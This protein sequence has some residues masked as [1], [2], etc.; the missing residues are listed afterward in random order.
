[1]GGQDDQHDAERERRGRDA[2][3]RDADARDTQPR[4]PLVVRVGGREPGEAPGEEAGGGTTGRREQASAVVQGMARQSA[5]VGVGHQPT[6]A[7]TGERLHRP[8]LAIA[9]VAGVLLA[10]LV[11]WIWLV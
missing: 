2:E 4:E 10:A 9:V 8:A 7:D 1:M 3:P 11:L 5:R 6:A